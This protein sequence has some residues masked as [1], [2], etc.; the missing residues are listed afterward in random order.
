LAALMAA[1][2]VSATAVITVDFLRKLRRDSLGQ[3]GSCSFMIQ[4]FVFLPQR[5]R[6]HSGAQ[7]I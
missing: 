4:R 1:A 5:H 6:E 2:G 3:R 7:G